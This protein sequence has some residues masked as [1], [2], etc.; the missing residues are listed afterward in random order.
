MQ[1]WR[2]PPASA[3][4]CYGHL[5]LLSS[6]GKS[7]GLG[8]LVGSTVLGAEQG[9]AAC[10]PP[11]QGRPLPCTAPVRGAKAT[12]HTGPGAK[13][14]AALSSLLTQC[15]LHPQPSGRIRAPHGN[16]SIHSCFLKWAF[17]VGL[18]PTH[19]ITVCVSKGELLTRPNL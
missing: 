16:F 8:P 15:T 6:P 4:Q 11:H 9:T 3:A 12:V 7:A 10:T 2:K 19:G 18:M 1:R 5:H 17:W 13:S 14:A